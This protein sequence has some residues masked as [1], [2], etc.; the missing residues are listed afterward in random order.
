MRMSNFQRT[1]GGI[2]RVGL[3]VKLSNTAQ[4][5]IASALNVDRAKAIGF[6]N[7]CREGDFSN[8]Q[9][10]RKAGIDWVLSF[11]RVQKSEWDQWFRDF[12]RARGKSKLA[13]KQAA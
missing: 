13:A 7:E 1:G 3:T 2:Q 8:L 4:E 6:V 11:T 10:L 12:K 9:E 5:A